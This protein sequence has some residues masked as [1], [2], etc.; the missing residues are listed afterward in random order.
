[1]ATNERKE[2]HSLVV[3]A[4]VDSPD[5]GKL[6]ITSVFASQRFD[7]RGLVFALKQICPFRREMSAYDSKRT[8]ACATGGMHLRH[9]VTFD[10]QRPKV[11][12]RFRPLPV[13]P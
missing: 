1:M 9:L 8:R 6:T 7:A 12:P 5:L 13:G 10:T 3:K 4:L 11:I 2:I